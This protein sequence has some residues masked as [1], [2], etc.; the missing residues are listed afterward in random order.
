MKHEHESPP[1]PN[2]RAEAFAQRLVIT[3]L[4]AAILSCIAFTTY[5]VLRSIFST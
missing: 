2:T 4:S 3:V 5:S 1:L